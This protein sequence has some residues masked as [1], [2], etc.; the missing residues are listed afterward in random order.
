MKQ[1]VKKVYIK[2]FVSVYLLYLFIFLLF[3]GK[4]SNTEVN[5]M[6]LVLSNVLTH[7]SELIRKKWQT[8]RIGKKKE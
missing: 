2:L 1:V 3:S 5:D 8:R 4:H 7:L 6:M